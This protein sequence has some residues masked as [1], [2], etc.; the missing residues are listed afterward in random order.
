MLANKANKGNKLSEWTCQVESRQ[1]SLRLQIQLYGHSPC[2][3][4][5]ENILTNHMA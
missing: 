2:Y 1:K 3:V 5:S 4:T